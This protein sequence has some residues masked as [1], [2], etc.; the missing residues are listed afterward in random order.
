MLKNYFGNYLPI[1]GQY[2]NYKTNS[3]VRIYFHIR[4]RLM[5]LNIYAYTSQSLCRRIFLHFFDREIVI[6]IFFFSKILNYTLCLPNNI[7]YKQYFCCLIFWEIINYIDH[8]R[9]VLIT[10]ASFPWPNHAIII[11]CFC[12]QFSF[13]NM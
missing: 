3:S 10:S 1:V 4:P 7:M 9:L 11:C 12:A 13:L 6:Y 5:F 8:P 2:G